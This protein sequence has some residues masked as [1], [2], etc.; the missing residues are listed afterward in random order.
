V[1][2]TR[3]RRAA[4]TKTVTDLLLHY[5]WNRRVARGLPAT[6]PA[7]DLADLAE[8]RPLAVVA[9]RRVAS[10]MR[11]GTLILHTGAGDPVVWFAGFPRRSGTGQPLR[12]P[13]EVEAVHEISGADAWRVKKWQ[14]VMIDAR[15]ADQ[16]WRLAVPT[17][18]FDLVQAAIS[19]LSNGSSRPGEL[20]AVVHRPG[21]ASRLPGDTAARAGCPPLRPGQRRN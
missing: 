19:R 4:G 3:P 17:I 11:K 21:S 15:A 16:P 6:D 20:T 8:G 7:L 12:A 1:I 9:H 2:T 5:E 10:R 13:A 18:D 14:F